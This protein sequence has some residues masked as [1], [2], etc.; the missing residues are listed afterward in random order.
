MEK[1]KQ[2]ILNK[3]RK[4]HSL[5]DC[6]GF[7]QEETLYKYINEDQEFRDELNSI[8]RFKTFWLKQRMFDTQILIQSS[9]EALP[10]ILSNAIDKLKSGLTAIKDKDHYEEYLK[11]LTETF[12]IHKEMSLLTGFTDASKGLEDKQ[13]DIDYM[14]ELE[15]NN[16]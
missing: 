7:T 3:Y 4:H 6:L 14:N 11:I 16:G 13:E 5:L 2:D 9:Y 8:K 12:R 15:E 10:E 1:D